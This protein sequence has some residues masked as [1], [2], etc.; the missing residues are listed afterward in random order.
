MILRVTP[1]AVRRALYGVR[2]IAEILRQHRAAIFP[3]RGA[4]FMT[5]CLA[6]WVARGAQTPT[7]GLGLGCLSR[8]RDAKLRDVF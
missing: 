7:L 4:S 5:P 1:T 2:R 6:W 3:V 8:I